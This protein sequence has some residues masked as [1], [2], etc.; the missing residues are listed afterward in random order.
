ML[1]III[2]T[3]NEEHYLPLL[4]ESIKRQDFD[5]HGYEIIIA[6]ADSRDKTLKIAQNYNCKVIDG[7]LPAKGKNKGAKVARGDLLLFLDA[8]TVLPENFVTL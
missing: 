4:L 7:G 1:S 2:P 8:D 3:L 5:S 6:D